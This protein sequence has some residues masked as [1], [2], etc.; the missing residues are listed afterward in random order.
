[1]VINHK[2]WNNTSAMISTTY[3][4]I[5]VGL[6]SYKTSSGGICGSVNLFSFGDLVIIF[7]FASLEH[8]IASFIPNKVSVIVIKFSM[9]FI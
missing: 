9:Q 8:L 2:I 5:N 6:L 7:P 4:L 3:S 1:M